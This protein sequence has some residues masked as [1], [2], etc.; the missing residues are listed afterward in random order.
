MAKTLPEHAPALS[1]SLEQGRQNEIAD[2]GLRVG[3]NSGA[4]AIIS[5]DCSPKGKFK[6][7]IRAFTR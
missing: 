1:R 5:F 7:S 3:S 2:E 4:S 6:L